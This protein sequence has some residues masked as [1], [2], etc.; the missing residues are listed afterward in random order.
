MVV[1]RWRVINHNQ[2]NHNQSN[3]IR[4]NPIQSN[5]AQDDDSVLTTKLDWKKQIRVL[6]PTGTFLTLAAAANENAVMLLPRI[7]AKVSGPKWHSGASR[8]PS[9][10]RR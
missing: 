8:L 3:S 10:A 1:A 2:F 4:S 5:H 9:R 7:V 6:L